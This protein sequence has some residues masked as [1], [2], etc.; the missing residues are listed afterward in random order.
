ME[1]KMRKFLSAVCLVTF[2]TLAACG[3]KSEPTASVADI[4]NTALAVAL[5]NIIM[6]QSAIP[7]NTAIPPT[8]IPVT[9]VPTLE[10]LPTSALENPTVAPQ[11]SSQELR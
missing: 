7:T 4:Q 5:T 2:L 3:P 11:T 6:T 8:P 10:L 9:A 1:K